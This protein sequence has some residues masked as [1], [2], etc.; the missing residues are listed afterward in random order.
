MSPTNGSFRRPPTA[1]SRAWFA[2]N[3]RTLLWVALLTVLIWVYADIQ[4]TDQR[5]VRATLRIYTLWDG[6]KVTLESPVEFRVKGNGYAIDRFLQR[7]GPEPVLGYEPPQPLGP[8]GRVDSMVELLAGLSE[9]HGA[10][11]QIV[12]ADPPAI[13]ISETSRVFQN[14]PVRL[15]YA[16]GEVVS[17]SVQLERSHVDLRVPVSQLGKIDSA[18]LT[19][20]SA[21]VNLRDVRPGEEV[22][23]EVEI[24]P[25]SGVAGARL[26]PSR[27][28]ARFVVLQPTE[29]RKFSVRV[30]VLAPRAW[31][32]SGAW[33]QYRLEVKDP[34]EWEK[35]I[36]LRGSKA[37]L[38][39]VEVEKGDVQAF[40]VLT[41]ADKQPVESWLPGQVRVYIK[42]QAKVQLAD[43][44]VPP[45]NF[46]LVKTAAPTPP[47][48]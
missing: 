34:L 14:V 46:R 32:D 28:R 48:P 21:P 40:I 22:S 38:D 10:G 39:K 2:E 18:G 27:V 25:P 1:F 35:P 3:L 5:E 42:P 37:D 43:E 29:T 6:Q 19:L 17:G 41:E 47:A 4:F 11:L 44:T 20:S 8:T 9:I 12:S 13:D 15:E 26:S 45:V 7:L 31:I 30:Q 24:L 16:G 33:S 36:A 23:Q